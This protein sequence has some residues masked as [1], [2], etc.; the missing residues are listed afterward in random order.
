MNN[1]TAIQLAIKYIVVIINVC[2]QITLVLLICTMIQNS[3]IGKKE[4]KAIYMYNPFIH[5]V[6]F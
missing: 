1:T 4:C 3:Q 6:K 5:N 2:V